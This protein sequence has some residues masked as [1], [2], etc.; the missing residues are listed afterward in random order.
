MALACAPIATL[1]LAAGKKEVAQ[2]PKVQLTTSLGTIVLQ[3][4]AKRAPK[5]VANFLRYVREGFYKGTIFHRVISNFMLQGGGFDT[6]RKKKKTHDPIQNEA[7]NG[8]KNAVGTVA[9][10]RTGD[11]HSASAQFFINVKNN[12]FLNFRSKNQRGWGYTVFGK[13]I[14][15]M[16]VVKKIK[17]V[18]VRNE[19]GPFANM[20]VTPVVITNAR[21]L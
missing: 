3:L 2:K 4:D 20:P 6:K 11:P 12:S 13:V 21:L 17:A 19:G 1:A 5:T 10:A 15:G 16:D 9:M 7:D 14:K 8:L 18:P